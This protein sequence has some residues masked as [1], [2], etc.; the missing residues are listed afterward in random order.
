MTLNEYTGDDMDKS[1][2][3]FVK[4]FGLEKYCPPV[5]EL[6]LNYAQEKGIYQYFKDYNEVSRCLFGR[7]FYLRKLLK[8]MEDGGYCF[9][10][11]RAPGGNK[12]EDDDDEDEVDKDILE[13]R[14]LVR[15][16]RVDPGVSLEITLDG[17]PEQQ[18]AALYSMSH[19]NYWG[20]WSWNTRKA[21]HLTINSNDERIHSLYIH[22]NK[23]NGKVYVGIT[24][25]IEARW[26]GCGVN[27][28]GCPVFY[29][30]IEKYGWDNFEHVILKDDLTRNEAELAEIEL[31]S[32]LRA[33]NPNFGY[34]IEAGGAGS[35]HFLS[36]KDGEI[37]TVWDRAREKYGFPYA[38]LAINNRQFLTWYMWA[39]YDTRVADYHEFIT[40]HNWAFKSLRLEQKKFGEL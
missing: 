24:K 32:K 30:A 20:K 36:V 31:I 22:I 4:K 13:L 3:D 19:L 15:F 10:G 9:L 5:T 39:F 7:K 12:K 33:N 37:R 27:Y 26:Y 6:F 35:Y 16:W 14:L 38:N 28:K 17:T 40:G 8:K 25:D 29:K 18:E 11:E 1:L 23:L 34:N 2:D 21:Q